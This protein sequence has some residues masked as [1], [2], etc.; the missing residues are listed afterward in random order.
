MYQP[1]KCCFKSFENYYANQTGSGLSFYQGTPLQRGYGFGSFFRSL[2]RAAVPLFKS[3]ARTVGKQ[4]LS[5][6][7][8]VLNDISQGENFKVAARRHIKEA[9]KSLTD[10]A[11]SKVKNMIGS[12][13][14]KKRKRSAKI[15]SRRK[16]KKVKAHD[17]FA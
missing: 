16:T 8:N 9:G 14:N 17:I 5:S 15:I 1:Y 4:L 6:G 2:F 3:G 12:G 13:R 11:A 10:K 7:V